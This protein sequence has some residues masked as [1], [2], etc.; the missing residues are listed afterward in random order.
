MSTIS[1]EEVSRL[2]AMAHIDLSADEAELMATELAVI[3]DYASQV[4]EVA[5]PDV[6]PTFQSIPLVNVMR[7][8]VAGEP[9][10]RTR[11]LAGAP[12]QEQGMYKVH[13]LLEED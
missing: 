11:L 7:K 13:R 5:T 10:D 2:A 1:A 8:D 6:P 12:D 4:S 9:I 3:A